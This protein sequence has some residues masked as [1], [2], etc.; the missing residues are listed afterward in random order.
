[1]ILVTGG[2]GYIGSHYVLFAREQGEEVVVLDNLAYGHRRGCPG[3]RAVHTTA[4]WA[5]AEML[6]QIFSRLQD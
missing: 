3:R 2:A 5:N 4:T 1:M 6:D